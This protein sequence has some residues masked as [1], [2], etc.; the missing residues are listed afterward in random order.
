[1]INRVTIFLSPQ[2]FYKTKVLFLILLLRIAG[3][4]DPLSQPKHSVDAASL[5]DNSVTMQQTESI[6]T[7][8]RMD[9]IRCRLIQSSEKLDHPLG[10]SVGFSSALLHDL[11]QP[12]SA[13]LFNAM[14]AVRMLRKEES[15][16]NPVVEESLKD[17][18]QE[19]DRLKTLLNGLG[20]YLGLTETDIPK[21]NVNETI[22]NALGLLSGEC[23]RRQI[24]LTTDLRT[25]MPPLQLSCSLF[26]RVIITLALALFQEIATAPASSRHICVSTGIC[27]GHVQI[28]FQTKALSKLL[29]LPSP[30]LQ[31]KEFHGR[32]FVRKEPPELI[33][34]GIELPF[35]QTQTL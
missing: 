28:C 32:I 11:R 12:V 14:A 33:T 26:T 25:G 16:S 23:V 29:D 13:I 21:C 1:M 3:N 15:P 20:I 24:S 5:P 10:I 19:V 17:I 18:I 2:D 31:L 22:A 6:P 9:S 30:S 35:N 7:E 4:A 8:E 34:W 27:D